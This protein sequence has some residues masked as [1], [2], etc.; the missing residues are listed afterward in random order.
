M[1]KILCIE[2]YS[3]FSPLALRGGEG[4]D[5]PAVRLHCA[6]LHGGKLRPWVQAV[7]VGGCQRNDGK[8][9][10]RMLKNVMK[11]SECVIDHDVHLVI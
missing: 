1:K 9:S 2:Q 4:Q 10:G 11:L 6:P 3:Y 7:G 8:G 5:C